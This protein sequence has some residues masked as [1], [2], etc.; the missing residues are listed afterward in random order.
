LKKKVEQIE[1]GW[2]GKPKG[3]LQVQGERGLTDMAKG[4]NDYMLNGKKDNFRNIIFAT[5]VKSLMQ[6]LLDFLEDHTCWLTSLLTN[7]QGQ[8]TPRHLI[9]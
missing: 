2:V 1:E 4:W 6:S 9:R 8:R 5:S 3:M 7:I